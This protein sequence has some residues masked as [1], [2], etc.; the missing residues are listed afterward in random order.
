[1]ADIENF[2]DAMVNKDYAT[3]NEMFADLMNQKIDQALDAEKAAV[4]GQVFNGLE[5]EEDEISDEDLEAAADDALEDE[6]F[7]DT[8][9]EEYEETLED[10]DV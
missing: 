9:E 7:D 1:M 6:D 10:E 5:P 3:S 8:D 4:A 2:I